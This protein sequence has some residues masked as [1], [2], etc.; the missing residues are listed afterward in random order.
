MGY[1]RFYHFLD[2]AHAGAL[3][4]EAKTIDG[5]AASPRPSLIRVG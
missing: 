3:F 4:A 1:G 5:G 2:P